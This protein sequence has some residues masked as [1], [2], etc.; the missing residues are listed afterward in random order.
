MILGNPGIYRRCRHIHAPSMYASSSYSLILYA[1]PRSIR[2][3][4][5]RKMNPE[6]KQAMFRDNLDENVIS[7]R[8]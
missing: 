6:K 7:K 2:D 4:T 1:S 5:Q 3:K 8:F